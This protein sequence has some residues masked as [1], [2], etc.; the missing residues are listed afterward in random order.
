M[1]YDGK[2]SNIEDVVE[3][4]NGGCRFSRVKQRLKDRSKK[5]AQTKERTKEILSKQAVLIAKH[6]EEHESF[7]TKDFCYYANTIFLIMLL[8]FPR[9]QKLFMGPLALALIVWR[10][11]LVFSS[12][13]KL[14]LCSLRFVGGTQPSLKQCIRKEHREDFHGVT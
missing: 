6:A 5:V 2:M 11:S 7:I 9:N 13:D 4:P 14:V 3:N 8:F 1:C 10:C 12:V